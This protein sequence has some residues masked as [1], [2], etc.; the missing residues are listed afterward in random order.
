MW[1]SVIYKEWLKIRWFLIGFA[2][3][4]VVAVGY[5]FLKVQHDFTF[6]EGKNYW[7]SVL[8]QGFQYF[9]HLKYIPLAGGIAIGVAQYFPETINKRIKLTF[10]LPLNE[11]KVMLMMM[12]FGAS[13]LL[14]SF[15]IM[16]AVFFALSYTFFPIEIV[17]GAITSVY[18]WFLA[19]LTGYF[20]VALV[21]LEPV[22]KYRILYAV[23]GGF[24][25]T[26]YL[27]SAVTE[28]YGPVNTVLSVL[29]VGLS[30]ALI[31]S[32]YR[33]RKGEM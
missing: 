24:F 4:G 7:Y 11:N 9:G 14:L 23:I 33:F 3:L 5:I 21:V 31:F 15:L 12:A 27:Q 20:L 22:W 29:T 18:P 19:G 26:I 1:K 25:A 30:I 13:S 17:I 28:G 16:F 6:F 2:V 8:F 32:G 10:H